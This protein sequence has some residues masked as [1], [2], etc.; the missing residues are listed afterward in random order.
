MP[1]G[2]TLGHYEIL[3]PIGAGGMGEVFRARDTRLGRYVAL[4]ILPEKLAHDPERLAR[5]RRE[6]Q[7]VAS[8]NHP[9]IVVVHSV[10]EERGTHFITMELVE[11]T[12]LDQM[13]PE[14]GL[15]LERAVEISIGMAEALAAAHGKGIVHRD[16]KPANVIVAPDGRVKVLDFGLATLARPDPSEDEDETRTSLTREGTV[17]GTAPYMSPEQAA[18]RSVDVR[19]DVFSLGAVIYE[20]L[21]GRRAFAG[22]SRTEI[23]A[24]VLR[25]TPT[26]VSKLRSGVPR[27]LGA[28]VERCLDKSPE[29]RFASGAEVHERLGALRPS[30]AGSAS[31]AQAL[32]RRPAVL[33]PAIGALVLLVLLG[34][35]G[36]RQR[37]RVA[38]AREEAVPRAIELAGN[39]DFVG[40]LKLAQQAARFAPGDPQVESLLQNISIPA[41]IATTPPGAT[42]R[43]KAY[44][45]VDAPW[46]ELGRTPLANI[47]L[48]DGYLKFRVELEGYEPL[49]RTAGAH[50]KL[51]W[52]LKPIDEVPQGMVHITGGSA[53]FGTDDPVPLG[54]FFIDRHEV[55]NAEFQQFV[56]AGGYQRA[57]YWRHPFV[58]DGRELAREAALGRFRDRTGRTGP[59]TWELGA[60]PEGT[61]DRPAS[62]VSWYEAAAYCEF[63]G[64]QLPTVFHWY[65][66]AS[67]S[68]F[69]DILALSNLGGASSEAAPV[70][71]FQ[72]VGPFGTYD[73]A[74]NVREWAFNLNGDRRSILGGAWSDPPYTYRDGY[75]LPPFD[76]SPENGIRCIRPEGA[77]ADRAYAPVGDPALDFNAVEPVDDATFELFRSLYAHDRGE[78]DAR[79]EAV[80]DTHPDWRHET[81]RF[82]AAYGGERVIAHLFLPKNASPPFQTVLFFP[83]SGARAMT[84][85]RDLLT[86][87]PVKFIPRTGRALMY[88]IFKGTF[89]RGGGSPAPEGYE[90]R[91]QVVSWARDVSRSLDYLETRDD[92]DAERIGFMGISLGAEY[93]PI[94]TALDDRFA[95]S[96]LVSGHLHAHQMG[97]PVEIQPVHFA[98]R[99]RV[100]VLLVNGRDDFTSPVETSLRPMLALQG[101]PE[102]HKRLVLLDG[103][104]LPAWNEVTRHVLDWL[105]RYLGPV[106]AEPRP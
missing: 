73:M 39:S 38:W 57:D 23:L 26:P 67:M 11:G 104:H 93:G 97:D 2:R 79:V 83:H 28:I 62:G 16:L 64:K 50:G 13:I 21:T 94:F 84:S 56:D 18:G 72:G 3:E 55:T 101:A 54:G 25:E 106:A 85:S 53:Q 36:W 32:M 33:A 44:R 12:P 63:A 81:V 47:R 30:L 78:L 87:V 45:D 74:G 80:D 58:L 41:S 70:A 69:S 8:L 100:P 75:A 6:A 34:A 10:E 20:L 98:S 60:F 42:V 99:S 24:A 102:A 52:T 76:R 48:A 35:W 31:H 90:R 71:R 51:D 77:V 88:P 29:R 7:A 40:A 37:A 19:S 1:T 89:E 82:N 92:I 46:E 105:D 43:Y 17:V 96:V 95:A 91:D 15:P 66:A 22:E 103:G 86:G 59:A 5:F 65:H 49:L 27:A 68:V 9:R 4:K 61:A 14:S